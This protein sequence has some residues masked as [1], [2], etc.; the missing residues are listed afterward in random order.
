MLRST[1]DMIGISLK[2][3]SPA[4]YAGCAYLHAYCLH[5]LLQDQ[6]TCSSCVGFAATAAL[7]AAVNVYKQQSWSQLSLSEQDFNFCK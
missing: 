6:Q 2:P 1:P 5:M 7:E 4:L 3:I